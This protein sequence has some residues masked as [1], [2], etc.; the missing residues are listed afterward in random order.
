MS[1]QGLQNP[2]ERLQVLPTTVN[3]RGTWTATESYFRNDVVISP[4]NAASYIL[5][6]Q[7]ALTGGV[8]PSANPDY[9]ELSPLSTG[10]IGVVQ[11]TGITVDNTNP[12]TPIIN[13][14]GVITINGDGTTINVDNTD[15]QNP[16]ISSNSITNIIQGAGISV[17][18][19]NPQAPIIGNTGVLRI[20][21]ADASVNVINQTGN[22]SISVNGLTGVTQGPGIGI[23]GSPNNPEISNTGVR[24]LSVNFGLSTTGGTNPTL[25]NTG[26]ITVAAADTSIIVT[27][28]AQ[29]VLLRTSA[30]V[31]T[32]C[33]SINTQTTNFAPAAPNNS[34]VIVVAV[35][36]LPN[37]FND[38]L[39]N[40]APDP[41]GIFMI[42]M[43][44][45]SLL[46]FQAPGGS[47]IISNNVCS[48]SFL[49]NASEYTSAVVL[50]NSYL[51]P[52][53][54]YPVNA[55]AGMLYFNVA[56]AR[57]AGLT[58]VNGIR[59]NNQTNGSMV[60]QSYVI[61]ING[62]YYPA[63]LQ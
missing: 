4:I 18:N 52:T 41:T 2:Y 5:A 24:T 53:Q 51:V 35:P 3:W 20:L 15:P 13:N 37:I 26:V 6:N 43:N 10:V 40:G 17:D 58:T 33:F 30:P 39:A 57:T 23:A 27:G 56:D 60:I 62:T 47:D 28:T 42:D 59:F 21:P 38:Y 46:F 1:I 19:N 49:D 11:G 16:V 22:V 44:E 7:T 61:P 36:P 63:G 32:R 55:S 8:D 54:S 50:N 14:A 31:A 25:T 9:V 48:V 34:V 45:L 29:D 12:Q